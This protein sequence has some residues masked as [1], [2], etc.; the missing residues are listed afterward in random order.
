MKKII[1]SAGLVAVGTAG[2]HAANAPGLSSQETAK[3]WSISA[4]LR[5]FYD[6]NYASIHSRVTDAAGNK[7]KDGS[8]GLEFRPKVAYHLPLERTYLGL[9]YEYGLKYYFDRVGKD[10]DHEHLVGATV[11]HKFTD[12]YRLR[13]EDSFVYSQ[14]PELIAGTG[15]TL[16]TY[17]SNA[18]ALRNRVGLNFT[19]FLTEVAGLRLGYNN[20]IYD[21]RDSGDGSYSALLDRIG[22]KFSAEGLYQARENTLGLVGYAY[23]I[24]DYTSEDFL[25]VGGVPGVNFRGSDRDNTS[26]FMYVGAEHGFTPNTKGEIRVG[27]MY[28]EFDNAALNRDSWSPYVNFSGSYGY[29]PG[30][31]IQAGVTIMRSSTDVA[32]GGT[33]ADFVSDQDTVNLYASINH[34][35]TPQISGGLLGQYQYGHFNGSG[36]YDGSADN[37]FMVGANVAYKINEFWSLEAIYGLDRLDS[38]IDYRGFT[39]NRV[40]G[41]VRAQY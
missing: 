33:Q 24:T 38:D 9:S 28:T 20:S 32:G 4:S 6:D 14:E 2:L 37:Y 21:Y 11:D 35:I 3:P 8:P 15:N 29:L 30:S 7:L 13:V 22:H 12:R 41:G 23:E 17:R 25:A 26:H 10:T 5:G 19:A 39:R 16:A 34:R 27:A 31:Y 40:Y 18:E 36:I 1:A